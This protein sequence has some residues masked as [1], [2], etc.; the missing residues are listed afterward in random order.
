MR[1]AVAFKAASFS[2]SGSRSPALTAIM[3]WK[4]MAGAPGAGGDVIPRPLL[5]IPR[6]IERAVHQMEQFGVV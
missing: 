2:C 4:A 1:P 3:I 6:R 5:L